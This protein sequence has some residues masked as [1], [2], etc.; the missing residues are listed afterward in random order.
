ME[1][2]SLMIYSSNTENNMKRERWHRNSYWLCREWKA[3]SKRDFRGSVSIFTNKK[4]TQTTTKPTFQRFLEL[5]FVFC[6]WFIIF[7][8]N[9]QY[10]PSWVILNVIMQRGRTGTISP[11]KPLYWHNCKTKNKLLSASYTSSPHASFCLQLFTLSSLQESNFIVTFGW[12]LEF[13]KWGKQ[14]WDACSHPSAKTL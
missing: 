12:Q 8:H 3:A 7:F 1:T 11:L 10:G 5:S 13:S 9:T 4:K 14:G 2:G 6:V